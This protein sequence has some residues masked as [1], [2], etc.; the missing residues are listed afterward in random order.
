MAMSIVMVVMVMI[1][2]MRMIMMDVENIKCLSLS[3]F[4][5]AG[6][7]LFRRAYLSLGFLV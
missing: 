2:I 7:L 6:T 1:M 4:T 5:I 3:S